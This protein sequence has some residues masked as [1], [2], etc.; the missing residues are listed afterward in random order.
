MPDSNAIRLSDWLTIA[1]IL[2]APLVAIQVDRFLAAIKERKRRKLDVFH[3]LMAT[4]GARLSP[5]HVEALN[6]IDVEF[7]GIREVLDAWRVYF[8]HLNPNPRFGPPNPAQPDSNILQ[9][10]DKGQDLF[11]ELLSKMAKELN[12]AFDPVVLKKGG[13]FPQLH[14]DIEQDLHA[15]RKSAR[16]LLEGSQTLK[17]TLKEPSPFGPSENL[18]H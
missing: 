9:W 8:D 1:A 4:R 5:T 14:T 11:T 17:V 13:Y 3:I 16:E 18:P 6:R 10:G 7:Y 12:Y 15:I 2:I